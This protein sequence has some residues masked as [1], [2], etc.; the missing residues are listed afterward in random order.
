MAKRSSAGELAAI[1]GYEPQYRFAAERIYDCAVVLPEARVHLVDP[2][3]GKLDDFQIEGGGRVDVYQLKWSS[4]GSAFSFRQFSGLIGDVATDWRELDRTHGGTLAVHLVSNRPASSNDRIKGSGG[5]NLGSFTEFHADVLL[6]R[7]RRGSEDVWVHWQPAVD[8]LAGTTGLTDA[9]FGRFFAAL[10]VDLNVTLRHQHV[11]PG[12]TRQQ[13]EDRDI[14][15][16]KAALFRLVRRR[17][18]GTAAVGLTLTVAEVLAEAGLGDRVRSMLR[19]RFPRPP[20]YRVIH[21]VRDRLLDRLDALPGGYVALTGTVGS[22]KSTLLSEEGEGLGTWT[23]RYSAYLPGYGAGLRGESETFLHDLCSQLRRLGGPTPHRL[24]ES[25]G[26]LAAELAGHLAWFAG[27][28][29]GTD[30]RLVLLVD[31]LDHIPREQ[32]PAR[33]LLADLPRPDEVPDGVFF[34][35]GTQPVP[36]TD[37]PVTL[38]R[39]II[40]RGGDADRRVEM[41]PLDETST[42]EIVAERLPGWSEEFRARVAN[43]SGGRPVFLEA[44]IRNVEDAGDEAAAVQV[45]AEQNLTDLD[46]YYGSTWAA[47]SPTEKAVALLGRVCRERRP[48]PL[49]RLEHELG[50]DEGAAVLRAFRHLWSRDEAGRLHPFHNSFQL[51]LRRET[52]RDLDGRFDPERDRQFHLNLAERLSASVDPVDR[53]DALHHLLEAG[54]DGE[55]VDRLEVGLVFDQF[56]EFRPPG[57]VSADLR[58]LMALAADRQDVVGFGTGLLGL[59]ACDL[60]DGVLESRQVEVAGVVVEAEDFDLASRLLFDGRSPRFGAGVSMRFSGRLFRLGRTAAARD[61]FFAAEPTAQLRT[62]PPDH[63]RDERALRDWAEAAPLFRAPADILRTVREAE[64][65]SP[66]SPPD[67]DHDPERLRTWLL[68]EVGEAVAAAGEWAATREILEEL[69]SRDAVAWL[70]LV[71]D[72][73][74][75]DG[76]PEDR[77][78]DLLSDVAAAYASADPV[79]ITPT[80]RLF[81]AEM[82][83]LHAGD[84]G[85]AKRLV[86]NLAP[87]A[88]DPSENLTPSNQIPRRCRTLFRFARLFRVC[89]ISIDRDR[90]VPIDHENVYRED[91][92]NL[93]RHFISLGELAGDQFRG[94]VSAAELVRR[95]GEPLRFCGKKDRGGDDHPSE[96]PRRVRTAVVDF[97]LERFADG[98]NARAVHDLIATLIRGE[99]PGEPLTLWENVTVTTA[100]A[101]AGGDRTVCGE[102]ADDL[103][104][105]WSEPEDSAQHLDRA[106]HLAGLR[107]ATGQPEAAVRLVRTAVARPPCVQSDKDDRYEVLADLL[108]RAS[109]SDPNGRR[110]R[111]NGTA[112]AALLAAASHLPSGG[113]AAVAVEEAARVNPAGAAALLDHLTASGAIDYPD[114]IGALLRGIIAGNP[115]TGEHVAPFVTHALLPLAPADVVLLRALADGPNGDRILRRVVELAPVLAGPRSR[116]GWEDEARRLSG[117]AGL[118]SRPVR[119][120]DGRDEQDLEQTLGIGGTLTL[121]EALERVAEPADLPDLVRD[122]GRELLSTREV[123]SRKIGE[124]GPP[125]LRELAD[126]LAGLPER[127]SE[128]LDCAERLEV[129]GEHSAAAAVAR[130]VAE[131]VPPRFYPWAH[132]GA[133]HRAVQIL[134]RCGAADQVEGVMRGSLRDVAAGRTHFLPSGSEFFQRLLPDLGTPDEFLAVAR[135]AEAFLRR[136]TGRIDLPAWDLPRADGIDVLVKLAG[137]WLD[138]PA[139]VLADAARGIVSDWH[140][141]DILTGDQWESLAVACGE[142]PE[143]AA[144]LAEALE[145]NTS[146]GTPLPAALRPWVRTLADLPHLG[147]RI[148]ASSLEPSLDGPSVPDEPRPSLLIPFRVRPPVIPPQI[149]RP[150]PEPYRPGEPLHESWDPD[151]V[152]AV[153]QPEIHLLARVAGLE[154]REVAARVYAIV[155]ESDRGALTTAREVESREALD[156]IGLNVLYSRPRTVAVVHALHRAAAELLDAGALPADRLPLI[157]RVFNPTDPGLRS[158]PIS[159]RPDE[160]VPPDGYAEYAAGTA[161]WVD[162]LSETGIPDD[163]PPTLRVGGAYVLAEYAHFRWESGGGQQERVSNIWLTRRR[164][165]DG[166]SSDETGSVLPWWGSERADAYTEAADPSQCCGV[167]QARTMQRGGSHA[168]WLGLNAAVAGAFGLRPDPTRTLGWTGSAGSVWVVRWL[169]GHP[170]ARQPRERSAEGWLLLCDRGLLDYVSRTFPEAERWVTLMRCRESENGDEVRRSATHRMS[171]PEESSSLHA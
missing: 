80:E 84:R 129:L 81:A 153:V 144:A 92:M 31:G 159:P 140:A 86:G 133:L 152:T 122:H 136:I 104:G 116:G 103:E 69:R 124:W 29:R 91:A 18:A 59:H 93:A 145:A 41:C 110:D 105:R 16:I 7:G 151:E 147:L 32:N 17:A 75:M 99:T 56:A 35:L 3:A 2:T 74:E 58:R 8:M 28:V 161:E 79:P 50:R 126:V 160:V 125:R 55:A 169:D 72:L 135:Q 167:R 4:I 154:R 36:L 127:E 39:L 102:I 101:A 150:D 118:P 42:A 26:E 132:D 54:A 52:A 134:R 162:R 10:H 141:S 47:A 38:R 45:L 97:I 20:A 98:E 111:V 128:R 89:G 30:R 96:G 164:P 64:F 146:R 168:G 100:L 171:L 90:W 19:H 48:F 67:P 117:T 83:A 78:D 15:A 107:L 114:V 11:T 14:E 25:R 5:G 113:T 1:A 24:P 95:L 44:L 23:V 157:T 22:G 27:E 148:A 121:R 68:G 87:G 112:R 109:A 77:R 130:G 123:T 6:G 43:A 33:S 46:G 73:L 106:V 13:L 62:V 138:H 115:V 37:L 65:E 166:S 170:L 143:R 51:F 158:L 61:L 85:A 139:A 71:G 108:A 70:A 40:D 120:D 131:G 156:D 142:R 76:I 34:V 12:T 163:A 94:G 9:E 60:A 137:T 63:R 88:A 149:V 119:P 155:A 21:P 66:D 49:D 82:L 57:G 165:A 53:W